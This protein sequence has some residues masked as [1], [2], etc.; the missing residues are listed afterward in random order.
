MTWNSAKF[1]QAI[2]AKEHYGPWKFG[3]R[4]LELDWDLFIKLYDSHPRNLVR[5]NAR[6]SN[7]TLHK[8]NERPSA[9]KQIH[10]MCRTLK[11]K[12]YKNNISLIAFGSWGTTSQSFN[13]H[14]DKMDVI[15][16]QGLGEVDLSIWKEKT[17]VTW[18]NADHGDKEKLELVQK[19]RMKMY[20]TIWIPRGTF[21]L[22]E[23]VSTRVG[24]SFGVEGTPDPCTYI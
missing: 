24:F 17:D 16:M 1:D 19:N 6:K 7:Y 14:R 3:D 9:P 18:D 12:F 13:I 10:N 22:I 4:D 20:D 2:F 15:Y 11:E 23:P 21:H 5:G 8:L